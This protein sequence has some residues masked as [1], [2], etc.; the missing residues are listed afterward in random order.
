MKKKMIKLLVTL[1]FLALAFVPLSA[2]G[3]EEMNTP[4]EGTNAAEIDKGSR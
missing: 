3:A 4:G 1:L 2:I